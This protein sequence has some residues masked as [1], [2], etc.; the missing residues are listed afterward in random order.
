M[1][2]T[3]VAR[4]RRRGVSAIRVR[5][6]AQAV[7]GALEETPADLAISLVDDAEIRRLNRGYRGKDRPTDVL[8]FA[9]REGKR[10]PG[11]E[12]VLGDVVI[13][14][15]TAARQAANRGASLENE[16]TT[17]LIHGIL[18]LLGYDHERSPADARRMRHKERTVKAA[19]RQ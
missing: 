4:V 11:D 6:H 5:R 15:D 12:A 19:L 1:A 7:L 13:S 8:A 14:L 9:M 18:H 10:A 16:V 3:V 17:L 2:V